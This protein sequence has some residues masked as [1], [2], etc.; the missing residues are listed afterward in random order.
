MLMILIVDF[1]R[2]RRG[3]Q[4]C[5]EGCLRFQRRSRNGQGSSC[6]LFAQADIG[7]QGFGCQDMVERSGQGYWRQGN[8]HSQSR[9]N[10]VLTDMLSLGRWP[11]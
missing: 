4:V 7:E 5:L 11:R 1:D 3:W 8:Y 9:C 10:G 2:C 6:Q